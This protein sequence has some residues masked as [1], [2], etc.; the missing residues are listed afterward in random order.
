MYSEAYPDHT[1]GHCITKN[2]LLYGVQLYLDDRFNQRPMEDYLNRLLEIA[3]K[4]IK[5]A[6]EYGLGV[7]EARKYFGQNNDI[8]PLHREDCDD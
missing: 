5:N 6:C 3:E 2:C 1:E 4:Y 8:R 7:N